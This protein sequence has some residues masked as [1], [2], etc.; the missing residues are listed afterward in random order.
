MLAAG[1]GTR[2]GGP[3]ALLVVDGEPL[4]LQHARRLR[5]LGCA[6][7][8]LAVPIGIADEVGALV[9]DAE[10]LGLDTSSQAATLSASLRFV[11]PLDPMERVLITPV[12]LRPP[13]LDTLRALATFDGDAV[14]PRHRGRNG[15]PLL[16]RAR[17][18]EPY[19]G[20]VDPPPLK[21]T[22][23]AVRVAVDI[24]DPA[25][26]GDFDRRDDLMP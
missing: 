9:A 16:V 8:V 2:M 3:K 7:V 5:A 21:E 15:H 26:L 25:V 23:A 19:L 24:D 20:A 6:R 18:L 4:I 17:L 1:R 10:V 13:R 22:L 14:F 11:G 12:D